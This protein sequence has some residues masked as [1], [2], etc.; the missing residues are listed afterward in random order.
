MRP[1][2]ASATGAINSGM[3]PMA[4]FANC[5]RDNSFVFSGKR[6]EVS[7]NL[8]GVALNFHG[9]AWQS[10]WKALTQ[11]ARIVELALEDGLVDGVYRYGALQRFSL[12][13]HG[14]D[15]T[16]SV[17]NL[18]VAAL[19]FSFGL[20]PWFLHH[21]DALLRFRSTSCWRGDADGRAVACDPLS[22]ETDYSVWRRAPTGWQNFCHARWDG[23]AEIDWPDSG[24]GLTMKADPVFGHLML[25]SPASGEPVFCIEPQTAAPCGFDGLETGL[26]QV[27][28][29]ILDPGAS[30]SGS[31]RFQVRRSPV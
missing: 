5:L 1:M 29:H 3:F 22:R 9:S 28:V 19:P 8:A 31:V 26:I 30:V 14:L 12:D 4:P 10:S 13:D 7:P 15:V 18:G 2:P 21:G 6:Y 17:T 24:I 23:G 11:S 16:I 27:G 20:H 25:H